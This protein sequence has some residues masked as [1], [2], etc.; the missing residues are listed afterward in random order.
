[1]IRK[2]GSLEASPEVA[3]RTL[4][5]L[6]SWPEWMPNIRSLE[7]LERSESRIVAAV[8]RAE[9]GTVHNTRLEF[10]LTPT[11][12]VERQLSGMARKWEGDWQFQPAPGGEG[13][14][15]S[16][17]LEVDLGLFG[18]FMPRRAVQR[19]VDRTFEEILRRV[20]Q[21]VSGGKSI[22][23]ATAADARTA[24]DVGRIRILATPSRLEIWLGDRK[25]VARRR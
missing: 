25:Y 14:V 6:E 10:L 2:F 15:V 18:I 11:G 17:R 22:S 16:C 12:Y 4:L 3:R 1:M 5:D 9:Y 8:R 19:V 24:L 21:R 23:A 7:V 20:D 13:S